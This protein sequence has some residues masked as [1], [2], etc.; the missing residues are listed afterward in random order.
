MKHTS[1]AGDARLAW[2]DSGTGVP[3][4]FVHGVI[5]DRRMWRA[6]E[7]AVASR[8]RFVALDLRHHGESKKAGAYRLA[9]HAEDLKGLLLELGAP[10][11]VL[12]GH[13]F[14]ASV[15]VSLLL[16]SPEL[17][18]GAVLVEPALDAALSK[19]PSAQG[20][21]TERNERFKVAIG[22][23]TQHGD[24]AAM[25]SLAEWTDNGHV[26]R[27][28]LVEPEYLA[29]LQ[30]NA[31]TFRLLLGTANEKASIGQ[32]QLRSIETPMLVVNGA[33]TQRYFAEV[34]RAV[35]ESL[36]KARH[37]VVPDASHAVPSHN[38]AEFN[39]ALIDFVDRVLGT[40]P[41]AG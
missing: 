31:H 21:L 33:K 25:R 13:S 16:L 15:V 9:Q 29:M 12:V 40:A 23:L 27:W 7:A 3:V 32:D 35:A 39:S 17:V 1:E 14:G 10:R 26:G 34:G 37:T 2:E 19:D 20:V 18:A 38:P 6:Q 4:V 36:P 22:A 5:C 28:D 11:T 41:A 8:Y 30:D 24:D